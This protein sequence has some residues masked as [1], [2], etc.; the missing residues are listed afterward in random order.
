[1]FGIP[2]SLWLWRTL[3][4]LPE[5]QSQRVGGWGDEGIGVKGWG[6]AAN[7]AYHQHCG[8]FSLNWS[9]VVPSLRG[10]G[11]SRLGI[12]RLSRP[13]ELAAW[14][15]GHR[16]WPRGVIDDSKPGRQSAT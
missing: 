14:A 2:G 5:P 10:L 7:H 6:V 3:E 12:S 13:H 16:L 15:E 4:I 9:L 1:M 11:L 8:Q